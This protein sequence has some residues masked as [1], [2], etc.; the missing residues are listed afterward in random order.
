[1]CL[2]DKEKKSLVEILSE[3]LE[4]E[5]R[6]GRFFF[7]FF[8]TKWREKVFGAEI[9]IEYN[10]LLN[11]QVRK[12]CRTFFNIEAFHALS[13]HG[14]R[15][16]Q[17]YEGESSQKERSCLSYIHSSTGG[18]EIF[19]KAWEWTVYFVQGVW[20]CPVKID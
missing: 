7:C 2:H 18:A 15:Q 19:G 4:L 17:M 6:E 5:H 1:M 13:F 20:R 14:N 11:L 10:K 9:W 3:K 16:F 12:E 8:V